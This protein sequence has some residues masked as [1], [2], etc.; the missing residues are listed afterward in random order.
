[1]KKEI[2]NLDSY[3][4]EYTAAQRATREVLNLVKRHPDI[5]LK[6]PANSL[7]ATWRGWIWYSTEAAYRNLQ[8]SGEF[9]ILR[10]EELASNLVAYYDGNSRYFQEAAAI[11]REL[12]NSYREMVGRTL[13]R[14]PS[15]HEDG[16]I[17]LSE[18]RQEDVA[19]LE[20]N[21]EFWFR[22][23]NKLIIT[24]WSL[25]IAE[26]RKEFSKRMTAE[27]DSFLETIR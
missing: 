22:L 25:E 16:N 10:D 20:A 23:T 27:I 9:A 13:L 11:T 8:Q 15:V 5:D 1:M 24:T 14:F 3:D 12:S 2:E 6:S 19:S 18:P 17:T 21:K 7:E 4:L 26:H